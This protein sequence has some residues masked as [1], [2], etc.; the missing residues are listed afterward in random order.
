MIIHLFVYHLPNP[1]KVFASNSFKI[2]IAT[3][4]SIDGDISY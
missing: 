3:K 2:D 4:L 1:L